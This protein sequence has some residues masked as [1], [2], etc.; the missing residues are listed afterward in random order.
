MRAV[1]VYG[2][3]LLA[4]SVFAAGCG[5]S[6]LERD[7]VD[8]NTLSE[9]NAASYNVSLGLTY[10]QQ[11]K[12][13][14]AQDKLERALAQN[15]RDPTVHTAVA[16]LYDRIGEDS[17]A[18]QHFRTALRMK[19]NDPSVQNYYGV[20]L[21]KRKRYAEG[22]KVLLKAAA[23]P[24]YQTPEVAMSNVG[25]CERNA[26]HLDVAEQYFRKATDM[27]PQ[28][29]E[30]WL[31]LAEVSYQ[32]NNYSRARDYLQRHLSLTR[33]SAS[34]LWLALRI[35]RALGNTKQVED[36]GRR[37]KSEFPSSEETRQLMEQERKSG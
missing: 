19:P 2:A 32:R 36:Y 1:A 29:A 3:M 25:V 18:E 10:L 21:C 20:F 30:G 31:Q 22:E 6:Q 23:S 24:L 8:P 28:F 13:E 16:L 5:P 37:L 7:A 33:V 17:K 15:P 14:L 27:K 12:I 11:G 35:E 9:T 26:G 34:A 4:A